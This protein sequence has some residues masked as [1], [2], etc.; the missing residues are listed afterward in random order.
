MRYLG[1]VHHVIVDGQ[2]LVREA[3]C[4]QGRVGLGALV[5]RLAAREVPHEPPAEQMWLAIGE[6]LLGRE[7]PQ[8]LQVQLRGEPRKVRAVLLVQ[9]LQQRAQLHVPLRACGAGRQAGRRGTQAGRHG[10]TRTGRHA[11]A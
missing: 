7:E 1:R 10:R 6:E 5:A 4:I 8:R 9:R 3:R 11:S 2:L